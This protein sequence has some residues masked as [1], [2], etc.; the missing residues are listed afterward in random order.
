MKKATILL[1][2]TLAA[3]TVA[4]QEPT[5]PKKQNLQ[6]TLLSD[7]TF[8]A[9]GPDVQRLDTPVPGD[10]YTIEVKANVTAATARG[11]DIETTNTAGQGFRFSMNTDRVG[12]SS[13]GDVNVLTDGDFT[14]EQVLRMAV[15]DGQV[16]LYQNGYYV[17]SRP[18]TTIGTTTAG[19][20]IALSTAGANLARRAIPTEWGSSKPTPAAQGW[21]MAQG[22]AQAELPG[23]ARYEMAPDD[24]TAAN[25]G[26]QT[27]SV[28]YMRWDCGNANAYYVY[29]V[30]LLA[31]TEYTLTLDAGYWNNATNGG[32]TV[33]ISRDKNVAKEP[34]ASATFETPAQQMKTSSFTFTANSTG[35]WYL[36]FSSPTEALY[37]IAN[38]RLT[39]QSGEM[40]AL[41]ATLPTVKPSPEAY[42][43]FVAEGDALKAWNGNG[44][45]T[46]CYYNNGKLTKNGSEWRGTYLVVPWNAADHCN[47][48]Y[49][50]PIYLEADQT[51]LL[52]ADVACHSTYTDNSASDIHAC[53]VRLAVSADSLGR[54][55]IASTFIDAPAAER[56]VLHNGSLVFNTSRA[57]TYYIVLQGGYALYYLANLQLC[58]ATVTSQ[59]G[60][61]IGNNVNGQQ[62]SI[63]I[64]EATWQDAAYAPMSASGTPTLVT[65]ADAGEVSYEGWFNRNVK[66]SGNTRLHITGG[67]NAL[68]G[69]TRIDL[70]DESN[71]LFFDNLR[72]QQVRTNFMSQITIGGAR[73]SLDYNYRLAEWG[74]ATVLIPYVRQIDRSALTLYT[75]TNCQGDSAVVGTGQP[76]SITKAVG[77]AFDNNIRS[78]H[79]KYGYMATLANNPDGTGYSRVF[80]A[81]DGDLTVNE[82]P[83]G[84]VTKSGQDRSFVSFVRVVRWQWTAKKGWAGGVDTNNLTNVACSYDWNIGGQS[85]PDI[86]YTPIHQKLYWPSFDDINKKVNVSHLLGL[87]EPDQADQANC[88]VEQA[89]GQWPEMMKSGLRVGSPASA[90]PTSKP[91]NQRFFEMADSL[92]YRVDFVAGHL[93][94]E[95]R[96]AQQWK[97]MIAQTSSQAGG[98]PVWIT[99]FNNGANWTNESWPDQSGPQRDANMN[100]VYDSNG[101]TTTVSRPL[102]PNNAEKQRAWVD[103]VLK[104]FDESPQ[105][106][107]YFIYN[108]VEDARA[109]VLGNKLTPAGKVYANH[110]AAVA[111]RTANAYNHT[112][113][114]APPLPALNQQ[115]GTG[116]TLT[117][118]DHNG[119][120]G[121]SY[122][123]ERS[124]NGGNWQNVATLTLGTHYQAGQTVT[125]T[126]RYTGTGTVRY[127]IRAVS[128]RGLFSLY[129][130]ILT[131]RIDAPLIA[132]AIDDLPATPASIDRY[133][134]DGQPATPNHRGVTILH[135]PD[136]SR[137]VVKR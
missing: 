62:A 24:L 46:G 1:A 38:M 109:M 11:L 84:F 129:S 55:P 57:G 20:A 50:L 26:K 10:A 23:L 110:Q 78:L 2:L 70:A 128:Y 25:G 95:S 81:N 3:I 34:I 115:Q 65:L 63:Y 94:K 118:Y 39:T 75:E 6:T 102:S 40:V 44:R 89:I 17:T 49:L 59:P 67:V 111:Y 120:T 7:V 126:D 60:I 98:R 54:T 41:P 105:L 76:Q 18:L 113:R 68:D 73:S 64:R 86:E 15:K 47:D 100:I 124:V 123:V 135:T 29:P 28:M 87:N 31:N 134:L 30:M 8:N 91:F 122:N 48:R 83:E 90:D 99:E 36:T 5:L 43:W 136:G 116:I 104:A 119:E 72:P 137:K 132:T 14:Q 103:A 33:G 88:S 53:G 127:R 58:Q 93:Y 130:R 27:G 42:G 52:A 92:N 101:G 80:I 22:G 79:L 125:F 74:M 97:D 51:I 13:G 96:N 108:W 106:E 133:T 107:R 71:W 82:L 9:T 69:G 66:V 112:W 16:H 77:E 121:R 114:I 131:T 21:L 35:Q 12:E 56:D 85:I 4:A 19:D 61:V 32:I 117:W 37:L 45:T